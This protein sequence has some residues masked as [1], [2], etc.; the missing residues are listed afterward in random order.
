MATRCRC[1]L[2]VL[3]LCACGR[4]DRLPAAAVPPTTTSGEYLQ[5]TGPASP[6]YPAEALTAVPYTLPGT[7]DIANS[8]TLP[9]IDAPAIPIPPGTNLVQPC[10]TGSGCAILCLAEPGCI[11]TTPIAPPP[12]GDQSVIWVRATETIWLDFAPEHQPSDADILTLYE[13]VMRHQRWQ[14]TSSNL[15]R[16]SEAF[17][18]SFH[19]LRE[20]V[21]FQI[22][23][24]SVRG[25]LEIAEYVYP[26]TPTP[27]PLPPYPLPSYPLQRLPAEPYPRPSS[28]V[29]TQTIK[30]P[31][32]LVILWGV[33]LDGTPTPTLRVAPAP[34]SA[35]TSPAPTVYPPVSAP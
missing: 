34:D 24:E 13:P 22:T 28:S 20:I 3:L 14:R 29:E 15:C 26:P 35:A 9:I 33:Q 5:A 4:P 23:T 7:T 21:T 2:F 1:I 17:I 31:P 25:C 10:V 6:A 16:F 11:T 18:P 8:P 32:T 27:P 12:G 19:Y 30:P